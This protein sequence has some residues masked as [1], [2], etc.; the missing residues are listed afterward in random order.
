MATCCR[1]GQEFHVSAAR[2]AWNKSEFGSDV[3]Y[4]EE[5]GGE[6]CGDCAVLDAESNRDLGRAI[7]M[8]NGDEDYDDDFVQE[9]L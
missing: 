6:V 1:C 7:D 8:V 9:H 2:D 4:E 5:F 3:D